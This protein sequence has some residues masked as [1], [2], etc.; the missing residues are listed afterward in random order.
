MIYA[1]FLMTFSATHIAGINFFG[2]GVFERGIK[3]KAYA[4]SLTFALLICMLPLFLIFP[5]ELRSFSF[6]V[7]L[8][9]AAS[10]IVRNINVIAFSRGLKEIS[11]ME[12]ATLSSLTIV[13]T[14]ITDILFKASTF[15]YLSIN[16]LIIVILGC[17]VISKKSLNLSKVKF[18]MVA[19]VIT[20]AGR[21]YLAYFAMQYMNATTYTFL[22]FLTATLMLLPFTKYFSPTKQSLKFAFIVQIFGAINM[23]STSTLASISVTFYMLVTPMSMVVTMLLTNIIKKNVGERPTKKQILAGI[24]VM[25]AVF[26]YTL[27]QI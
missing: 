15:S 21:G 23:I 27:T 17:F 6:V 7:A 11:P 25:L 13:I 3:P 5:F 9:I 22:L 12:M 18:A 24:V 2:K 19:K 16:F 26:G 20:S 8:I 10:A 4:Y 1:P 14:Y